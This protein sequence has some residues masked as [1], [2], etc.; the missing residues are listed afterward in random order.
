MLGTMWMLTPGALRPGRAVLGEGELG[1]AWVCCGG[2]RRP[3]SSP[4]ITRAGGERGFM[5]GLGGGGPTAKVGLVSKERAA[6]NV[7]AESSADGEEETEEAREWVAML[8][9]LLPLLLLRSMSEPGDEAD[10]PENAGEC[11]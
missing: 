8:L 11:S 5:P 6:L 10:A 3:P 1:A 7:V 4:G 9:L 2:A